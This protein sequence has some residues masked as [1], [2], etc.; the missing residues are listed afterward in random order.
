ML[1]RGQVANDVS[2]KALWNNTIW[3]SI[4]WNIATLAF[5]IVIAAVGALLLYVDFEMTD[6]CLSLLQFN[7]TVL[8][9]AQRYVFK[10]TKPKHET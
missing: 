6:K 5:G 7:G 1:N 9:S 4:K 10:C 8:S 2:T 3:P